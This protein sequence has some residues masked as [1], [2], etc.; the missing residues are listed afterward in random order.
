M[1]KSGSAQDAV[2][3]ILSGRDKSLRAKLLRCATTIAEPFYA[4][5]MI[6][7]NAAFTRGILS[8]HQL[9]K[10]T[11]SVGNITTGGTGKTPV[12][13]W[14]AERLR[15]SGRRPAVLMRGYRAAVTSQ[16]DEQ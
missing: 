5:A 7:R 16:S 3:S 11:I 14:L 10:P 2:M 9:P 13:Q 1:P 4:G 6:V 15:E 8:R 12:V